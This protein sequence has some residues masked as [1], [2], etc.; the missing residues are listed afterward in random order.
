MLLNVKSGAQITS[1]RNQNQ[2]KSCSSYQQWDYH[3]CIAGVFNLCSVDPKS[4]LQ[5]ARG[6]CKCRPRKIKEWPVTKKYRL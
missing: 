5:A 2:L 1:P 4:P 6:V 3:F